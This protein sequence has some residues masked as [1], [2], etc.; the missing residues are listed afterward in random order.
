ME[1]K[2]DKVLR[3][4]RRQDGHK[5]LLLRG[6]RQVGKSYA[7]RRLGA[8]YYNSIIEM[9]F[10]T[11][12]EFKAIFEGDLSADSIYEKIN[13]AFNGCSLEGALLFLDEIQ[14]CKNAFSALKPLVEDGR[15][16]IACS[17]SVLSGD[18]W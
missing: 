16:D 17:G 5:A 11:N 3:D 4:W 15:C 10:E 8:E 9:N 13:F 14:S 18:C 2:I 12:P 1:R 7:I 6:P